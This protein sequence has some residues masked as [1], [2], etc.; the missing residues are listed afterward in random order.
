[1]EGEL[2]VKTAY[3]ADSSGGSKRLYRPWEAGV[4][5]STPNRFLFGA[6][7]RTK[8]YARVPRP[9]EIFGDGAILLPN[10]DLPIEEG[11][12]AEA[13]PWFKIPNLI[14]FSIEG[15]AEEAKNAA[16]P[17]AASALN[18]R[19]IAVGGVW[20]RGV[21]AR[22]RFEMGPWWAIGSEFTLQEALNAS[23]VNWERG[24]P[25]PGRPRKYLRSSLD[26]SRK[27][28]SASVSHSFRSGETLDTAG[29]RRLQPRHHI[30]FD[31]GYRANRWRLGGEVRNLF[32]RRGIELGFE[33]TAGAN[34]LEPVLEQREF[35]LVVELLW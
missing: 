5:T 22:T 31:I 3:V 9:S 35:A 18:A 24:R 27:R 21:T 19:V 8:R 17:V 34:V 33:G 23:A 14:S 30:G 25:L 16:L 2:S 26:Y 20:V 15:F 32:P 13:G 1:L 6:S 4:Y 10:P 11:W 7:G 29:F 12:R 28:V